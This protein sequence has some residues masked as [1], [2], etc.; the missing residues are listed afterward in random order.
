MKFSDLSEMNSQNDDRT[1]RPEYWDAVLSGKDM[2]ADQTREYLAWVADPE[3]LK[4][5]EDHRSRMKAIGA[6]LSTNQSL[7]K[8]AP[9]ERKPAARF[10]PMAWRGIGAVAA[11]VMV[12]ITA[13]IVFVGSSYAPSQRFETAVGDIETFELTD[14]SK[15]TLNTNTRIVARYT[16][17]RRTIELVD[18]QA[19]F[20]VVSDETRPFEVVSEGR[21]IR[22]TGTVFEVYEKGSNVMVSVLEGSVDAGFKGGLFDRIP[23]WWGQE[24]SVVAVSLSPGDQ[25]RLSSSAVVAQETIETETYGRWK[26]GTLHFDEVALSEIVTELNRYSSDLEIKINDPAVAERLLSGS[27]PA[28]DLETFAE[29]LQLFTNLK[30]RRNDGTIEI[31]IDEAAGL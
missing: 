26:T 23:S 13:S 6:N 25:V 22:V 24:Q 5:L 7:D 21:L 10:S 3:N 30:T 31:F 15:V 18:G 27:F 4:A 8:E 19:L 28:G 9:G 16:D 14:G 12:T 2:T 1:R 29:N 20:D 11:A 17:R